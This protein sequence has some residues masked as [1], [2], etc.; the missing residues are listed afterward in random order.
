M[1]ATDMSTATFHPRNW[2]RDQ[3]HL[4]VM[5]IDEVSHLLEPA[6]QKIWA[7]CMVSSAVAVLSK[8]GWIAQYAHIILPMC[9]RSIHEAERLST[10]WS[11]DL[12][13]TSTL[14]L[15]DKSCFAAH[16]QLGQLAVS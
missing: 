9:R 12:H 3:L 7:Q 11:Q 2:L 4:L 15:Y 6:E 14:L 5:A 1:V 13:A 8:F 16:L 10:S